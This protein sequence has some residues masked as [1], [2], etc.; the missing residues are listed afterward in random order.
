MTVT[1]IIP[2]L[3][4]AS[5]WAILFVSCGLTGYV[6]HWWTKIARDRDW[7]RDI[8]KRVSQQLQSPWVCPGEPIVIP[9]ADKALTIWREHPYREM[10][11]FDYRD[12]MAA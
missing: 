10:P 11:S 1:L 2:E 4:H 3:P 12:Q 9:R 7:E 8:R 6:T 5:V